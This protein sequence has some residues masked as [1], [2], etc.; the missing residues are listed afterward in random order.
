MAKHKLSGASDKPVS[1]ALEAASRVGYASR[2]FVYFSIGVMALFAAFGRT[3]SAEGAMGAL[4]ALSHWPFGV[5]LLWLTALGLFGFA[6]WRALQSIFDAER[7]G[8]EPKAIAS[9]A[10]Q[11]ISGIVY[12]GLGYSV[13]RLVMAVGARGQAGDSGETSEGVAKALTLPGGE[14]MVMLVGL[15]VFGCG[16]G[17]LVQAFKRDFTK[18]LGCSKTVKARAQ[19]L[20]QIGYA[21]RGI[22]F[23][24]AG[25]F[26]FLAGQHTNAQEAK[27]TGEALDWL[28]ALPFGQW[29]LAGAAVGLIAFGLFG[30]MEARFRRLN[31]DGV[32]HK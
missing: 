30:F 18:G 21:G 27:S 2:G 29:L 8:A 4:E 6:A 25:V 31:V 1:R 11:A 10:G 16:V 24:P 7:Q 32:V 14:W 15:F 26:I 5:P 12:A 23:L 3:A 17:N 13:L 20:G 9:R 28:A 22:V 19:R